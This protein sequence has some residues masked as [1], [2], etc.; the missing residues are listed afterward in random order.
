MLVDSNTESQPRSQ[1]VEIYGELTMGLTAENVA[2]RYRIS[3][4]EQDRFALAS[5]E[6]ALAAIA[7]GRFADEVVTVE[8]PQRKGSPLYFAIDEHPRQTSLEQLAEAS[9]SIQGRRQR[10]RRQLVRPQRWGRLSGA[11]VGNRSAAPGREAT[12]YHP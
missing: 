7:A 5:Q 2:E 9:G 6:K 11:D 4:E 8:V 12:R 1:P 3:R 10:Y